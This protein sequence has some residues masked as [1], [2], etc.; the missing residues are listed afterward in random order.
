MIALLGLAIGPVAIVGMILA[1]EHECTQWIISGGWIL[2]TLTSGCSILLDS[3]TPT[4]AWVLLLFTVGLGHGLLLSGY[5]VRVQNIPKDEDAPLSTLPATISYYARSWGWAF[6][7]PVGGA[8][9]LN[10]FGRGF[11]DVGLS[12]S[13]TSSA[14]GYLILTKDANMT[15]EQ[16]ANF[17]VASNSAFQALWGVITGAA[18]L[19][20]ISSAF[21]WRKKRSK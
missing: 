5:N 19:G 14:N 4:I 1:R 11:T 15:P 2:T 13:L 9:L 6:A 16:R 3:S 20:G 10:L 17:G 7:V 8:V 12:E 21:L 18:V